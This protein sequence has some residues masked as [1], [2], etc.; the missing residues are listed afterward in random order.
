MRKN[1]KVLVYKKGSS[2]WL[3][4]QF[5]TPTY[6]IKSDDQNFKQYP[7]LRDNRIPYKKEAASFKT[8]ITHYKITNYVWELTEDQFLH[9]FGEFPE[10]VNYRPVNVEKENF[11]TSLIKILKNMEKSKL[12]KKV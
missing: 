6:V 5:E 2:K 4:G 8:A 12:K 9:Q 11:A 10:K 3:A 1:E 7:Y